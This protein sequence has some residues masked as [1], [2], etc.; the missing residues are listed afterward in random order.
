MDTRQEV[1]KQLS[2]LDHKKMTR[3]QLITLR[4][5]VKKQME[6]EQNILEKYFL[7]KYALDQEIR[8]R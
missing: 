4:S 7:I 1:F 2:K 3:G 6:I 5:M 8:K